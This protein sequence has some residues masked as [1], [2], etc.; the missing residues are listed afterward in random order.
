[1]GRLLAGGADRDPIINGTAAAEIRRQLVQNYMYLLSA[2]LLA[3]AMYYL[4]QVVADE[5]AQPVLVIM[6]FATGLVSDKVVGWMITFA[7]ENLQAK[8]AP[9]VAAPAQPEPAPDGRS[10]RWSEPIRSAV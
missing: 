2:P 7:E 10:T 3:I 6:S 4:L 8:P 1:M 9:D 5:V